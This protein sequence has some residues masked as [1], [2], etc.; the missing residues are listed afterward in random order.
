MLRV[1][2]LGR[3]EADWDGSEIAPSESRRAWAL[4]GWMALH[5]GPNERSVVAATL[6]P[7]VLD[8][9]ARTSL[10]S[11]LWS[12]R[13]ALGPAA[14]ALVTDRRR[15]GLDPATTSSRY[16]SRT[17]A[18]TKEGVVMPASSPPCVKPSRRKRE[19]SHRP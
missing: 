15:L 8:S 2:V 3:L 19:S 6:W 5:P 13:R 9:S 17:A 11:A 16:M 12:L 7:D 14:A 1:Q 4:L 10:R 18:K